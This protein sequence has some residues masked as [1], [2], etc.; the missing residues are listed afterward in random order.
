MPCSNW[1]I[2]AVRQSCRFGFW[3]LWTRRTASDANPR[4]RRRIFAADAEG[5]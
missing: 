1:P 4:T 3:R 2:A 5:G